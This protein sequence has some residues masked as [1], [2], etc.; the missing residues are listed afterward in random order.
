MR[1][2]VRGAASEG[3]GVSRVF[4]DT[5][6]FVYLVE[7]RGERAERVSTLRRRM[8]ER[9]DK[10]LTSALTLGE[11]LV[12]PMETGDEDLMRRYEQVIGAYGRVRPI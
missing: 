8:I 7:D 6:L 1:T 9:D 4:R 10:L 12:K 5:N 11:V 2:P 3:V